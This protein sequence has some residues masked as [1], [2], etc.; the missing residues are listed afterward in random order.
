MVSSMNR[1]FLPVLLLLTALS[2]N[3]QNSSTTTIS[4]VPS[5]VRF[6]VD[7]QVYSNAVTFNW[8]TGSKHLLVFIT[9]PPV[10][11]Q[12][13]NATVQT[14]SDGSA[15]YVFTG[16]VDNAGLLVPTTDPVQTITANPAITTLTATL[17]VSY[18][19]LLTYFNSPDGTL[20]ATCG[21]PGG[22]PAGIFR[23]G[24]VF[25]GSQCFW[26]SAS[27][28]VPAN[29]ALSLNAFPY[30]GFVFVGWALNS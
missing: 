7:G 27:V 23:P 18:R 17:T 26:A 25:L 3:A 9:D 4:T 30:P 22:I 29:Q 13:T 19:I 20:P 14:A 16:W 8:P 12:T 2:V 5:G 11:N 21:A 24:V 15:Q 10:P 28:F 1:L 6:M